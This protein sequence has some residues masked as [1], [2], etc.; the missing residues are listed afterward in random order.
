MRWT[1]QKD[2]PMPTLTYVPDEDVFPAEQQVNAEEEIAAIIFDSPA[3]GRPLSGEEC[4]ELGQ[5]ILLHILT[6]FRPDLLIEEN[7]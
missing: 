4:S 5:K 3:A 7:D 1:S 6:E 2:Y